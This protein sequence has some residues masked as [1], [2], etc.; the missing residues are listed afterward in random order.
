MLAPSQLTDANDNRTAVGY[1][2]LGMVTSIAL[3]DGEE[4]TKWT[5]VTPQDLSAVGSDLDDKGRVL[6]DELSIVDP[7]R[8]WANSRYLI[9][10]RS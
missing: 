2:A 5:V 8:F 1:D 6:G 4:D 9:V 10:V 3:P 7:E